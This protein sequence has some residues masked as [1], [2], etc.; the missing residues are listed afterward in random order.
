MIVPAPDSLARWI[1][2]PN[3]LKPGANMPGFNLSPDD[4]NALVAYLEGLR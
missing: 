1:R 4:I 2:D 3:S